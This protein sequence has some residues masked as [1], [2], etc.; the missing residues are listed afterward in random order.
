MA[1]TGHNVIMSGNSGILDNL[2][3]TSNNTI[4]RRPDFSNR[5]LSP[6][7]KSHLSRFELSKEYGRMV[8]RNEVLNSYYGEKALN[9][10]GKG[11]WHVCPRSHT[12]S[13]CLYV[14]KV[15]FNLL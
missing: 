6:K 4:R 5:I 15:T 1:K 12:H 2:V 11:A 14:R 7:Q 3:L 13:A 9:L 10:K 8:I